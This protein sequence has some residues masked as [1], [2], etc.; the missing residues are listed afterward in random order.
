MYLSLVTG[1]R[2]GIVVWNHRPSECSDLVTTF[3]VYPIHSSGV[4]TLLPPQD[5]PYVIIKRSR[6]KFG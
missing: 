3:S 4:F 5:V 1:S 6:L 2:V